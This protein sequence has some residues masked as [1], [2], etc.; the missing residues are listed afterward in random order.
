[1]GANLSE[2]NAQQSDVILLQVSLISCFYKLIKL[3]W[4]FVREKCRGRRNFFTRITIAG[5]YG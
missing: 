4:G 2:E 1:V 3:G 5:F